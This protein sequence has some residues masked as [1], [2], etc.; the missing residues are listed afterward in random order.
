MNMISVI[1]PV[2]NVEN[3]WHVC[4]NSI[5]EQSY[6]D[7]EIICIDD[8]STDSSLEIL[9]YF[10]KKDSRVKILKNNSN[11]GPGFSRNRGLDVAEG[12]YISFLDGD[13]W[14]SPD[15]FETLIKKAEQDTL[16]LL[17]F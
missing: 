16:D 11:R 15:A 14:F 4:L 2:Y 10:A 12:K 3:Y 1:I 5:L 9:E 13:D 17:L 6:G 7:F 8:A